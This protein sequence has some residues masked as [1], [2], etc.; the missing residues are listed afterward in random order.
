MLQTCSSSSRSAVRQEQ[1]INEL[2]MFYMIELRKID[3]EIYCSV[4]PILFYN[5]NDVTVCTHDTSD[6]KYVDG[7]N[8]CA[9]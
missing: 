7:W 2:E 9:R 5:L 3:T 8:V 6:D 1:Q 4:V